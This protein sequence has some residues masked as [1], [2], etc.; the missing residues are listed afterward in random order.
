MTHH[1]VAALVRWRHTRG[2]PLAV[3]F[4]STHCEEQNVEI[5]NHRHHKCVVNA[6]T[7]TR[8][9]L[10]HC[11]VVSAIDKVSNLTNQ[12][13]NDGATYDRHVQD[14]GSV[15]SERSEFRDPQ[16][17]YTREHNRVEQ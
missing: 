10:R 3:R 2:V 4:R 9:A 13:W 1:A 6:L 14:A 16:S 11:R 15:S 7:P 8:L 17:E 5:A 12:P